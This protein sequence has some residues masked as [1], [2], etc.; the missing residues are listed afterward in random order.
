MNDEKRTKRLQA[1]IAQLKAGKDVARRDVQLALLPDE[2]EQFEADIENQQSLKTMLAK[3]PPELKRYLAALRRADL[4][5]ARAEAMVS[6]DNARTRA[7]LYRQAESAYEKALEALAEILG[8]QPDLR[9]WLD[10][11]LLTGFRNA[12]SCSQLSVPRLLSSTSSHKA[13]GLPTVPR[14]QIKLDVLKDSLKRLQQKAPPQSTNTENSPASAQPK[15]ATNGKK[16]INTQG[17]KI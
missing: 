2:W 9:M 5:E 10:R 6:S 17:W 7:S 1:L 15:F 16:T 12:T 3:T 8:L 13:H 11:D 14:R 4:L